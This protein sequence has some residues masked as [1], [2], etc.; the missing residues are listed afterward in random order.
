[1]LAWSE[2]GTRTGDWTLLSQHDV[3]EEHHGA[4]NERCS[5]ERDED[6]QK[7]C[8]HNERS[9]HNLKELEQYLPPGS[10]LSLDRVHI[11]YT[12]VQHIGQI[13]HKKRGQTPHR[14]W[15]E[16]HE[17]L[18]FSSSSTRQVLPQ[19]ARKPIQ[20]TTAYTSL[21]T[22]C[23]HLPLCASVIPNRH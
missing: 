12:P 13:V 2:T 16:S 18:S 7:S 5:E 6:L 20:P 23:S 22:Y 11:L 1:M 9:I 10:E 19:Q 17:R 8:V 21:R 4:E 3:A 15:P 14:C